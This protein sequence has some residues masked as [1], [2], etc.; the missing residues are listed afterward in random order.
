MKLFY[1]TLLC[2]T[3]MNTAYGSSFYRTDDALSRAHASFFAGDNLKMMTELRD[4]LMSQPYDLELK[5]SALALYKQAVAKAGT[6]GLPADWKLPEEISTM[7]IAFR[8]IQSDRTGYQLRVS[9]EVKAFGL[10]RQL[11]V[12]HYPD[13]VILDKEAGIGTYEEST[14][15]KGEFEYSGQSLKTTRPL[16]SGLYLLKG[17]LN[18]GKTVDGWFLLEDEMNSTAV[19]EV[20]IPSVDQVFSNGKPTFHWN[21]FQSPQYQPFEI[22]SVWIGISR[23]DLGENWVKRWE[24]WIRS[25]QLTELTVG[26]TEPQAGVNELENGAYAFALNYHESHSF[27]DIILNRDSATYRYF[28][29]QK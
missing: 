8:H 23:T 13:Q 9:G 26:V 20:Q 29:V 5:K 11:Q 25:P 27:G 24:K 21:N 10:I 2:L 12:V 17:V 14:S 19:P 4:S 16:A 7:K 15:A 6:K 1:V 22:R 18:S 28:K 3:A